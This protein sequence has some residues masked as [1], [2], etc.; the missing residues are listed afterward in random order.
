M[1]EYD[2]TVEW[3]YES[4]EVRFSAVKDDKG[5]RILCRVPRIFMTVRFHSGR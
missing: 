5:N 2:A 4:E 1:V 3:W